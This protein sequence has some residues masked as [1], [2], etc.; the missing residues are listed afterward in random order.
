MGMTALGTY[1]WILDNDSVHAGAGCL[2]M[3]RDTAP[4]AALELVAPG[5][6][7][8]SADG[9]YER[10]DWP[11]DVAPVVALPKPGWTLLVQSIGHFLTDTVTVEPLSRSG[12]VVSLTSNVNLKSAFVVA[13]DGA[14]RRQFDPYDP[15]SG[16]L[17]FGGS[18]VGEPLPDESDPRLTSPDETVGLVRGYQLIELLTGIRLSKADVNGTAGRVY[19]PAPLIP[20]SH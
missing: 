19:R 14:I 10:F 16:G 4:E 1:P 18:A 2:A 6:P 5:E 17:G 3:V 9:I 15:D 20:Y 8:V 7:T 13:R 12:E 11:A